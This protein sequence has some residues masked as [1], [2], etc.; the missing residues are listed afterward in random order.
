MQ[1]KVNNGAVKMLE[2]ID[3]IKELGMENKYICC[4]SDYCMEATRYYCSD[5]IMKDLPSIRFFAL[6][7]ICLVLAVTSVSIA[8]VTHLF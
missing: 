3:K 2:L 6:W 5:K 7:L 8:I 4:F 1:F